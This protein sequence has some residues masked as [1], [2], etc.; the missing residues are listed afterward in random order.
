MEMQVEADQ[1][2]RCIVVLGVGQLVGVHRKHRK[3]VVM[4]FVAFRRA[5][6]A[7]TIG[8]EIGPALDGALGP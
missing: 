6:A 8:A 1:C 3:V 5:G 7:I 2:G 4:R